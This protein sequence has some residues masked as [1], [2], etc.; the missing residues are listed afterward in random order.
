M[1]A[2]CFNAAAILHHNNIYIL[3]GQSSDNI[4][5]SSVEVWSKE[6][7]KFI[8]SKS[9]VLTIPKSLFRIIK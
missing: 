5:E 6:K 2:P 3:G 8:I 9:L 1:N 7:E 4:Y